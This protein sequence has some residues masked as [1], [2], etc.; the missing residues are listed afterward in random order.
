MQ[1]HLKCASKQRPVTELLE[2]EK[3]VARIEDTIKEVIPPEQIDTLISNIG[4]PVGKGAGF[5]TVLSSNSGPD[6][7]YIIVNLKQEGR[8]I[9]TDTHIKKLR[10]KLN[11]EYPLEKFLFVSGG[12][13][14]LALNKGVPVPISVQL[15]AGSLAQC[16]DAAERVVEV[17]KEIPRHGGCADCAI[18]GLPTI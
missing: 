16:R 3:L 17:V 12:I 18:S 5:S 8:R 11:D 15:S 6:T 7:A 14:N 13:V 2:T 4:L 10:S 1:A 9:S